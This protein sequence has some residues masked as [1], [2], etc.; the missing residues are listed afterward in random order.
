[1]TIRSLL[2]SPQNNKRVFG[3]LTLLALSA[4]VKQPTLEEKLANAGGQERQRVAYEECLKQGL[5]SVP[6]G[7]NRAYIG[8]EN[9]RWALCD[10]MNNLN[11][12]K[13]K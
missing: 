4:C 7:H 3:V 13:E 5:Y 9:R 1:M 12:D 6:G 8:H 2:L 11:H 10:E